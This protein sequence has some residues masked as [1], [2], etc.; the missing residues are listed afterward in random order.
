MAANYGVN[1]TIT[2]QA[3]RP[4]RIES[5]TPIAIAGYEE[6]LQDGL[7]FFM[8]TSK[9]LDE[10]ESR[11]Q[12]LEED[13]EK[14][15]KEQ[16]KQ[17]LYKK[18]SIYKSLKA[19][20]D[21]AVETGIILSVF[22][23]KNDNLEEANNISA[24]KKAIEE[25][26]KAKARFSYRPN[27]LIAPYFSHIDVIRS[28]LETMAEKLKATAI[29]D[30]KASNPSEA[31]NLM[32]NIG[33]KRLIATYPDVKVWDD[34]TNSYTYCGQSPRVAG[35][36]AY[37]DGE[38]EFGYSNSYSN[39]VMMGIFGT[40]EDIDFELGESCTAD[41]LRVNHV[42]TIINEQGYR[43]WG[44]ETS[45]I[46]TIWQDL[47]RVRIFDRLSQ[48][49]QK[50]VLFAIDKKANELY[51]AKRSVEELLR[52]LVGAKVLLG[53]EL[54]FSEKNTLA[55]ITAGKFYIDVKLQNNPIV[56]LLT[57][58]FI[59]VDSYGDILLQDLNK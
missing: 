3:S 51:H 31:I 42:S 55:N 46:D 33:S 11:Y 30:L 59:Y 2:A 15:K 29:I 57:L 36:I 35:M 16:E 50:G 1:V 58:D 49:C 54:S 20:Q 4:I 41:L 24:C 22:T 23:L 48:A 32:K 56:K 10:L 8:S 6:V 43:T 38:D 25:L 5:T 12:A 44:G 7:Y 47:A 13:K 39:R 37:T 21:Q 26:K 27:L 45:H 52:S 9:A 40:S 34:E 14:G 28:S 19:I 17:N 53:F 18:G